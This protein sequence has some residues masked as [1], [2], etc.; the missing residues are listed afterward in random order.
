MFA[1][2]YKDNLPAYSNETGFNM[3]LIARLLVAAVLLILCLLF[4]ESSILGFILLVLVAVIA[5]YDIVHKTIDYVAGLQFFNAP[6][7]ICF[8]VFLAFCIGF[9]SE[10][11]VTVIIYQIGKIAADFAVEKTKQTAQELRGD[12]GETELEFMKGAVEE[13][14]DE[15][16]FAKEISRGAS[17]AVKLLIVI[18]V[19]YAVVV[20]LVTNLPAVNGIHNA[21]AILVLATPISACISSPLVGNLAACYAAALG[22]KVKN[23]NVAYQTKQVETV[24][25]DKTGIFTESTPKLLAVKPEVFD[26][27]TFMKL[28]ANAVYYSEQPFADAILAAGD[29][30]ILEDIISDFNDIPGYGVKLNIQNSEVI[31]A[32][33]ELFMSMGIDVPEEVSM[34]G[35]SYYM[36]VQRKYVGR[37]IIK[38]SIQSAADELVTGLKADGIE[39]GVLLAEEDQD[40]SEA[41]A[42]RYGF[43]RVCGGCTAEKKADTISALVQNAKGSAFIYANSIEQHSAADIDIRIGKKSNY[44]DILVDTE[45]MENIPEA[46]RVMRRI[47]EIILQ[48]AIAAFV[49]KAV[50]LFLAMINV[51]SIWFTLFVDIAAMLAT[52]LS[53]MRVTGGKLPER[54]AN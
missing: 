54:S 35:R 47:H 13:E 16:S 9:G 50:L 25:L 10:A 1:K 12:I 11:A 37:V 15:F 20:P 30:D 36:L 3:L 49:V 6:V 28:A 22:V 34:G 18:A 17:D 42:E 52:V 19:A 31:L 41:F 38:E 2:L 7:I 53:A 24:I 39:T 33:R 29:F 23:L 5:G 46:V 48:N 8:T 4:V 51:T 44:A 40:T 26:E 21:L 43:D 32:G 45:G 14:G 27:R